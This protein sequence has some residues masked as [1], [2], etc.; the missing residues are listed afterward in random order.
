[1]AWSETYELIV[2]NIE[3]TF[4]DRGSAA[5]YVQQAM[6]LL[7]DFEADSGEDSDVVRRAAVQ[8]LPKMK[9]FYNWVLHYWD[10]DETR[11]LMIYQINE[12][13]ERYYGDLTTFVNNILWIDGCV[14]YNWA[15]IS[16]QSRFDTSGWTICS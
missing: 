10:I 15:E 16:E 13:T 3:S 11:K 6:L 14:P 4:I 9:K 7:V 5:Y 1:M 12:F 8:L 2:Y